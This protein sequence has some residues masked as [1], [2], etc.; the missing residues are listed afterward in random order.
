[1]VAGISESSAQQVYSGKVIVYKLGNDN[2]WNEVAELTPSDPAKY[3]NFGAQVAIYGNSIVVMGR[4]FNDS[5]ISRDKLYVFEK[6]SGAEWVSSTETYVIAKSFGNPLEPEWFGQFGLRGNELIVLAHKGQKASIEIYTKSGGIFSLTQVVDTPLEYNGMSNEWNLAVGADILV[7]ATEQ[8]YY[9]DG[10][11]GAAFIYDKTNGLY[12]SLP[13]A[14]RAAEQG[15]FTYTLFGVAVAIS[16]NT[17]FIQGLREAGGSYNQTFYIF[18]KPPGGWTDATKSFTLESP[19]YVQMRAQLEANENYLFSTGVDFTKIVGFK[20]PAGGWSSAATRFVYEDEAIVEKSNMGWKMRLDG[21]H[22]VVGCPN[23]FSFYKPGKDLILDYYEPSG[24][25]EIPDVVQ[26]QITHSAAINATDDFFGAAFSV[27]D[28]WLAI[29]ASGD[30]EQGPNVGVVYVF[31]AKGQKIQPEQK[32]FNPEQEYYAGFGEAIAIGDSIMFIGAPYKDSL[33]VNGTAVFYNIG[34]V[35]IF[36]LTSDG[37]TYSSQI[38]APQIKGEVS[39]GRKIVWSAGYCAVTEF[40]GGD[41]ESIGRVHIYKE[42]SLTKKFNY[43]ATLDPSVHLRYDFFGQSMVMNDSLIVIGTGN[44]APNSDYRMSTYVFKKK[45]EWQNATE[46]ARLYSTDA[47]WS[48]RFGASVSMY[49]KYIVVGAPYSPGFDPRPIP[50]GYIIPGAAYIFK[51]PPGGWNGELTEIAKLTP[52]DPTEFG[53]FGTAVSI[54]HNDIFI[55]SPNRFAQYNVADNLTNDDNTLIPGKVYHFKKPVGGEWQSTNQEL[56]Q[57]Q[58]FEPDFLDGYGATMFVSDRYLYVSAMLDDT[59]SGLRTGS[60]QTMMQLPAIDEPPVLCLDSAPIRLMGFPKNGNWRGPAVHSTTGVFNPAI[61]GAGIH[62]LFYERSGCITSVQVEVLNNE[63]VIS[64]QSQPLQV[65]C[66]GTSVPIVFAS[67]RQPNDYKWYFKA[68]SDEH[69]VKIDSAKQSILVIQPGYYQVV[70][71][72]DVCADYV[73]Q[74]RVMD[75]DPVSI[76]IEPVPTLCDDEAWQLSATPTSGF[77]SGAFISVDGVINTGNLQDGSYKALYR[78]LTPRGCIWKD[79]VMVMVDKLVQ[80][81][82]QYNGD[83]ICGDHPVE[84]KVLGV[85]TRSAITWYGPVENEI[86]REKNFILAIDEPGIYRAEVSKLTC[87]LSTPTVNVDAVADSLYIPNVFTPND[88]N[89]NNYF[90]VRSN[91]IEEFNLSVFNRYGNSVFETTN[92]AFQWSAT[93]LSAGVYFWSVNYS[94]C[95][96]EKKFMK[97]W[98]QVIK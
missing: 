89:F 10:S 31:D 83:L 75:E 92:L 9:P 38:K 84:L 59:P 2:R 22:L 42:D 94:T 18:E 3:L 50:R 58:S 61:A 70:I 85:D 45:G 56:R 6:A 8:F 77:W 74:F 81:V 78:F 55:G 27:H 65:K 26:H 57:F 90:E 52:S 69:Y 73:E 60:V 13:K 67:N 14:L 15:T 17:V 93:N 44:F 23:R 16:N 43:L 20:K 19:G 82:I 80:P 68:T 30:D 98:V 25:W 66:M 1:M 64:Q 46:D 95:W 39:F 21:N 49:G 63:V 51:Q 86:L 87:T 97:G 7:I 36:R 11:N 5:G 24:T 91:G 12:T 53:T 71:Y 48:D 88:D 28:D 62:T 79:S 41:S 76:N 29:S 72:R 96:K 37:W 47:G 34:K 32:I 35:Y 4:D 40:Y 54:D 33:N